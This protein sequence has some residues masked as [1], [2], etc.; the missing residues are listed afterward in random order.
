MTDVSD[1]RVPKL[2]NNDLSYT[3]TEWLVGDDEPIGPDE[4]VATIE[5][6]KSVQDLVC[7]EGGVLRHLVP[8]GSECAPGDVVARVVPPGTPRAEAAGPAAAPAPAD[9]EPVITAPA[10]ALMEELGVDPALVRALDVTVV[11]RA[12]VERLAAS[13]D[14]PR[15]ETL[16]RVQ[17]AV[18]RTVTVSHATIPAAYTA[19]RVDVGAAAEAAQAAGRRLRKI[20]GLPELLVAAVATLHDT[21]PMF[22]AEPLDDRTA[23]LSDEPR[24]GVTI[25][26][27]TG[28]FV[29]VVRD[30]AKRTVAD[31]ADVMLGFRQTA[32]AGSFREEELTGGNI[33]VTLHNDPDVV[34]AVPLIFPGQTAALALTGAREELTRD[35]SGEVVSATVCHIGLAYDHRF[36]NGRDATLFLQAVKTALSEPGRLIGT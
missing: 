1:L 9:E 2:N 10:R 27:G 30:A 34:V 15:T 20:I 24:I 32:L 16:S 11:R 4:I 23:R 14:R 6:S 35:A 31:V 33:G 19:I 8:A 26:V 21:F 5:T 7:A 3:L 36:V 29:P 13:A 25:D 28:L 17:Q 12:D 18:A 22:F